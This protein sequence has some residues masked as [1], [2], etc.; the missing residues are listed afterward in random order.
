MLKKIKSLL[1]ENRTTRQTVA[2]NAFWLTVSNVGGRLL[3]AVIIIYAARVLG[4][5][6]W[7]VFS[8]A[9]TLAAFFTPFIDFG[10]NSV[11]MK[12]SAKSRDDPALRSRIISTSFYLKL[13]LLVV[14]VAIVVFLVPL[15]ATIPEVK[16]I[17][18][19]ISLVMVFDTLR[20]FTFSVN[21]SYE[22]M[23]LEAGLFIFTNLAIVASGF[24]FLK[25]QPTVKA[26][27]FAYTLGTGLGMLTSFYVLR[28]E[29]R[30]LLVD[31]STKL[32]RP[33]IAACWPFAISGALGIFLINTDILI[34]GWLRSTSDV[35]LYS[36]ANRFIQIIYLFPAILA[37]AAL[38]AFSR[39]AKRDNQKMRLALE[40]IISL[41]FLAAIPTAVGGVLLAKQIMVLIFG[42]AYL[43]AT[44]AFQILILTI[45]IDFPA[46]IL[47]NAI[48]S[49]DKQKALIV[50]SI[51]GGV[52]NVIFDL[53]LIPPF[54][55][56]GSAWATFFAQF[57]SNAYLWT[58][59]KRTNDFQILPHLK[60][61]IAATFI[62]AIFVIGFLALRL[63]VV[64][65]IALASLIYFLLLH[66]NREPLLKE[67]KAILQPG[68]SAAPASGESA[69]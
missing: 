43:G 32:V 57:L 10:I 41:A 11:L 29:L 37:V 49:Y 52:F 65:I 36:A 23:E 8:Y 4:T 7:G 45:L 54:G 53:L 12:E 47:S 9:I 13:I 60:K 5:Y 38:P 63:N 35:G 24:A 64:L 28:D 2:K 26:F 68:A 55:I 19:L 3:R 42:P 39:L 67:I 21:Q 6:G 51:I 16:T 20:Q 17:L 33:I 15:Y 62:M 31:F 34:I 56:A 50:Y 48:F 44:A 66:F 61:I 59:M 40:Q 14:G 18:W 25:W 46:V 69:A 1:L 30:R 22:R 27:T 58:I